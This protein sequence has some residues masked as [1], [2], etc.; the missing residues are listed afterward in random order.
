MGGALPLPPSTGTL[1]GDLCICVP[2]PL[3]LILKH[4]DIL[5]V[6]MSDVLSS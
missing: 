6:I 4:N 5:Y 1:H 3:L 2:L